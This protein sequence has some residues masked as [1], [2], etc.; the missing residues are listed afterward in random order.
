MRP[1]IGAHFEIHE[2]SE[3]ALDGIARQ[4]VGRGDETAWDW[5]E[6]IRRHR[7]HDRLDM[8]IWADE[9]LSALALAIP[10]SEAVEVR[11]MEADPRPDCPLLGKRA[12]IALDASARYAQRLGR[13]ELRI[14]PINSKIEALCSTYGFESRTPY[15]REAYW[16][17]QV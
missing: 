8:A 7:D 4:W 1:I 9:R 12:L 11:F 13:A 16:V 17:K 2:C 6:L 15:K 10:T 3:R 5:R 14:C